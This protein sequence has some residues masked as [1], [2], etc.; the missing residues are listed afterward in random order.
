[1]FD[2]KIKGGLGGLG[3]NLTE[4]FDLTFFHEFYERGA[5]D[6]QASA[7]GKLS[8]IFRPP[9]GQNFTF[10]LDFPNYFR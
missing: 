10:F 5:P 6:R 7:S 8:S 1:M 4:G 2:L 3:K 9:I